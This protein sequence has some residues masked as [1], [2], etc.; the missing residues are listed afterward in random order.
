MPAMAHGGKLNVK[1]D[2]VAACERLTPAPASFTATR[3]TLAL[4]SRLRREP[5]LLHLPWSR[6]VPL[7]HLPSEATRLLPS[8][9]ALLRLLRRREVMLLVLPGEVGTQRLRRKIPRRGGRYRRRERP[10]RFRVAAREV[11][12]VVLKPPLLEN[13]RRLLLVY[14]VH[15]RR[16]H[17]AIHNHLMAA[18]VEAVI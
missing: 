11:A 12:P 18:P 7:L 17:P 15:R 3:E 8:K 14:P 10:T 1:I 6:E 2:C 9:A 16:P 4:V 5:G 13:P